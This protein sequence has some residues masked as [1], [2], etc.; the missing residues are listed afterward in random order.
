LLQELQ[1]FGNKIKSLPES[2]KNLTS[3]NSIIIDSFMEKDKVI[4]HIEKENAKYFR[5]KN[6]N[7]LEYGNHYV[8][9]EVYKE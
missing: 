6:K 4:K 1:L 5:N 2:C 7:K 3:L 9:I 8:E